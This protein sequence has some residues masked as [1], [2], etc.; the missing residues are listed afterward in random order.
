MLRLSIMA[1]IALWALFYYVFGIIGVTA[2]LAVYLG[3]VILGVSVSGVLGYF[4][5]EEDG[6]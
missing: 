4:M 6:N 2:L 3:I 5:R 1:L